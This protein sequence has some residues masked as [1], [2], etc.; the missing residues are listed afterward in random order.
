MY[1]PI[2]A[3]AGLLLAQ[4]MPNPAAA[5]FAGVVS[6]YILDAVPHGD[7]GLG[8]WLTGGHARRRIVTI[9]TIDLGLAAI[10]VLS[11]VERH[12]AT[13]WLTLV[14]GAVGGIMPD[15]LWGVRFVFDNQGWR[16]PLITRFLHAH[17]R[18]HSW[19]HAK[20]PY[21]IPFAAGIVIQAILLAS[22]FLLH[23]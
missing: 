23:L 5:F 15:L 21:D 2:H 22:V 4:F 13:W 7:T 10:V 6:H 1:S 11:M 9:E 19:G 16:I 12:S 17:D 14:A 3:S 8:P 18:W 20:H